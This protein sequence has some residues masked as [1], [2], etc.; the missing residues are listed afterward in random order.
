MCRAVN[1]I[2]EGEFGTSR[3]GTLPGEVV[4][5]DVRSR[6]GGTEEPKTSVDARSPYEEKASAD[7]DMSEGRR[8][9]PSLALWEKL[10]PLARQMRGEPT[11]AEDTL[12]QAVRKH[13]VAGAHFRRQ[14]PVDR[15]IVDFYCHDAGL[16]VEVDG[17]IH[18]YTQ[19]EDAIR[20]EFLES[21]G[22]RVLRFSNEQVLNDLSGVIETI[23][24]ALHTT[25]PD[26][27][28]KT[29]PLHD[30]GRGPGGGA[31]PYARVHHVD[32][33]G[34]RDHKYRALFDQDVEHTPWEHIQPQT[35]YYLF[36]PYD[37]DL[38]G[39]YEQG[40]KIT[41]AM[42][43]N[44]LGFQTHRD[45]FAIDFDRDSLYKR[46]KAMR[47]DNFTDDEFR[48]K[49]DVKDNRDWQLAKARSQ[50]RQNQNWE[51]DL[52]DCLYRPFDWRPC[53]YSDVA[54]DYP[55][56]ELTQHVKN[57]DNSVLLVTR[58]L[59]VPGWRH[60]SVSQSVAESCVVSI[61]TKEQN[62][63]FPLYLYPNPN[64]M[65]LDGEDEWPRGK[66]GRRPNLNR[67]FI[68]EMEARLG[69]AFMP[70]GDG[71]SNTP[72]TFTPEDVFHYV[73]AVFH[74][75][76][77]RE[78]YAEFLKIDFPRLPLTSDVALFRELCKHGEQLVQL[79]LLKG[80]GFKQ[81]IT[82]FPVKG[83]SQ[84]AAR[85]PQYN[86]AET[87]VYINSKQ[88]F[89]GVPAAVWEFHVGGYQVLQKW[90]KDRKGRQ[91]S[92]DDIKHYQRIVVALKETITIMNVI[93]AAIP[94]W[95][96]G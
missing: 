41:E 52:I 2:G 11:P 9:R 73:Y 7:N 21:L 3:S 81:F 72:D 77:Y 38:L 43:V 96:L 80:I 93:D 59:G 91:L 90:L 27:T 64:K 76:T 51:Q 85:H 56:Y 67:A 8:I 36:T 78:R 82:T 14:H 31:K 35:P 63:T 17:E 50:L 88:Y 83:D 53:Y 74:C 42:P 5:L 32:L 47:D 1:Q 95:P 48:L 20:Q 4:D 70:E 16:V 79:H 39:E 69:L 55:R 12:W 30:V 89:E 18:Q 40:W 75:P 13:Q 45:K 6:R 22:L 61:K 15:F 34:L 66:D 62:Y 28:S 65:Q 44:V 19:A 86:E 84:V 25:P 87:R 29:P 60:V 92:A 46:I 37:I 68:Q 58:Q 10:K 24:Q 33:W 49:Y 23:T 26:H 71:A 57:R 94:E 54:M